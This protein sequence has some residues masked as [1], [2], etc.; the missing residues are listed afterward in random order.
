MISKKMTRDK[1][2]Y[3][4]VGLEQGPLLESV[5][6]VEDGGQNISQWHGGGGREIEHVL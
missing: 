1:E 3:E 4:L 2:Q 5:W 6:C